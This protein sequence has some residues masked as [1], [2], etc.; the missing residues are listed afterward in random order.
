EKI[1]VLHQ[2][3]IEINNIVTMIT[4]ISDQTNLLA[5]NASI[6]AARAGENGKGF[7][8]VANEVRLLA[9]QSANA[10][11]EISTLIRE[12]QADMTIAVKES[13]ENNEYVKK[14][15]KKCIKLDKHSKKL[16][17]LLKKRTI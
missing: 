4:D 11:D 10:T 8:V 16:I 9:E 17:M 7:A 1:D 3:S 15:Q 5:L 13:N 14:V 12:V 6:E 2:K